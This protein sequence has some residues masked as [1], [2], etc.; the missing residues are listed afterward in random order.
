MPTR[1][2]LQGRTSALAPEKSDSLAG[3]NG[4]SVGLLKSSAPL[5]EHLDVL[6]AA[7]AL[8]KLVLTAGLHRRLTGHVVTRD[9]VAV[10][11]RSGG[12]V[13]AYCHRTELSLAL[14][15]RRAEDVGAEHGW[16][17]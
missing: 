3:V 6:K 17:V 4:P 5:A 10:S 16:R 1:L 13:A 8:T 15:P 12:H 14:P 11:S 9:Y 2:D 7:P